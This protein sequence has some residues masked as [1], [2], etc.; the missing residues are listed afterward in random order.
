[1]T[2]FEQ[3][4]FYFDFFFSFVVRIIQFATQIILFVIWKGKYE[5]HAKNV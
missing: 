1:M 2:K 4:N 5:T 3:V